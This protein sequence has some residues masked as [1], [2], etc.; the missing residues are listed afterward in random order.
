MYFWNCILVF[1][2]CG[3]SGYSRQMVVGNHQRCFQGGQQQQEE[4]EGIHL[5]QMRRVCNCDLWTNKDGAL[6]LSVLQGHQ[7]KV[8]G[9]LGDPPIAPSPPAQG[10]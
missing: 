2:I 10:N 8:S 1:R 4:H 3:V 9:G 7:L 6:C 5:P